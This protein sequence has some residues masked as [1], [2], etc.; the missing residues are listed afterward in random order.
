MRLPLKTD[1]KVLG[2][3][4]EAARRRF[5]ALERKL[6]KDPVLKD[7]NIEFMKEYLNL[8]HM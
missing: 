5:L 3:S 7:M 1:P 8:G 4:Y 2:N 6:N